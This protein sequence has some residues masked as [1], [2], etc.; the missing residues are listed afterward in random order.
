MFID[1]LFFLNIFLLRSEEQAK[2]QLAVVLRGWTIKSYDADAK[3][4]HAFQISHQGILPY[5]F[6]ADSPEIKEEW[7]RA[8]SSAINLESLDNISAPMT[9]AKNNEGNSRSRHLSSGNELDGEALLKAVQSLGASSATSP[10]SNLLII[11]YD[12]LIAWL[13][14]RLTSRHLCQIEAAWLRTVPL[15][16][17]SMIN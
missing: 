1:A 9:P 2:P 10:V 6:A 4:P 13:W 16:I 17:V 3:R 14:H 15:Q 8:I 11:V 5:C 7:W 12:C